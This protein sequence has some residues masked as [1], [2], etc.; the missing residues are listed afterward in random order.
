[1]D[2]LAETWSRSGKK[3]DDLYDGNI[4]EIIKELRVWLIAREDRNHAN[5]HLL[6]DFLDN[7]AT[8]I[9]LANQYGNINDIRIAPFKAKHVKSV[10]RVKVRR[11]YA[12]FIQQTLKFNLRSSE[13]IGT[14]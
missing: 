12:Y 3:P 2:A 11:I 10:E 8:I 5:F 7:N 14:N 13:K 9:D 1:M 4:I 6:W